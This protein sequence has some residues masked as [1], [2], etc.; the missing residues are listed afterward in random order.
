MKMEKSWSPSPWKAVERSG[1]WQIIGEQNAVIAT[2]GK[3]EKS[4]DY[5][6]LIAN[7]PYLLRALELLVYM[8]GDVDFTDNDE[9][10]IITIRDMARS[11]IEQ[12]GGEIPDTE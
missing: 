10:S 12:A 5:A 1:S 8:V 9:F 3:S 7:S 4:A 11:A 2:V 6:R